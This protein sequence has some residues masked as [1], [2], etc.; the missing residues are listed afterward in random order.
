MIVWLEAPAPTQLLCNTI[1]I[2][3]YSASLSGFNLN[4]SYIKIY[5]IF[6]ITS[7]FPYCWLI[8]S[9]RTLQ[10]ECFISNL[11]VVSVNWHIF[12]CIFSQVCTFFLPRCECFLPVDNAVSLLMR[13]RWLM[14]EVRRGRTA[15][16]ARQWKACRCIDKPSPRVALV[17]STVQ[18]LKINE[19][20]GPSSV[21]SVELSISW[22]AL[23]VEL[24]WENVQS[25]S[26]DS[27]HF[28]VF[29]ITFQSR[30]PLTHLCSRISLSCL[31][32]ITSFYLVLVPYFTVTFPLISFKP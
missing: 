18:T 27:S 21:E 22:R 9:Q 26:S 11:F 15:C 31:H 2:R 14:A 19:F 6:P 5:L 24:S 10:N 20:L 7:D 23:S 13:A 4:Y 28:P 32:M 8:I 12:S 25:L 16:T 29:T 1:A 30:P 3:W 17:Y